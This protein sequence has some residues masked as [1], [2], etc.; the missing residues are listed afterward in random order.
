MRFA[1]TLLTIAIF[2]GQANGQLI[3]PNGNPPLNR[4]SVEIASDVPQ[5]LR[6]DTLLTFDDLDIY[7]DGGSHGAEFQRNDGGKLMLF[8]PHSGYWTP[9]A[10]KKRVQP[11]AV[12]TQRNGK[13]LLVEIKPDSKLNQRIVDLIDAD[14]SSGRH[15][16]EKLATLKRV[17]DSVRKRSP[18]KEIAD[19]MDSKTGELKLDDPF[20]GGDA[21]D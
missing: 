12:L 5:K 2:T 3:S 21:F 9:A 13:Q 16:P 4:M 19:R 10:R 8:F 20:G 15:S 6:G 18:L 1:L 17:R 11:V 7:F 14:I